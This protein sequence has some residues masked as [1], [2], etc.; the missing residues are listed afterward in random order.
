[1]EQVAAG[2]LAPARPAHREQEEE[3][4]EVAEEDEG[5]SAGT[6]RF[7]FVLLLEAKKMSGARTS[8]PTT[9]AKTL[10]SVAWLLCG[11]QSP[12]QCVA[13]HVSA[14]RNSL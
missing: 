11:Q 12:R 8:A 14:C 13:G 3:E 2:D 9:T 5:A 10:G 4:E 1:M 6:L 7:Y